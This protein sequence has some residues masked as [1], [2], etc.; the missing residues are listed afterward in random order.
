MSNIPNEFSETHRNLFSHIL[1]AKAIQE[2]ESKLF[3]SSVNP[4]NLGKNSENSR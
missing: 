2:E 3:E 1:E 4:L